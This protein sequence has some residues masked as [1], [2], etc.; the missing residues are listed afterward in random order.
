MHTC[1]DENS[2]SLSSLAYRLDTSRKNC[3]N[4]AKIWQKMRFLL[5]LSLWNILKFQ[6]IAIFILWHSDCLCLK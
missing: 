4:L 6:Y 3:R 1:V 2:R 5:I